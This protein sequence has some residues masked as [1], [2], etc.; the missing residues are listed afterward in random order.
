MYRT[1]GADDTIELSVHV[2]DISGNNV[3]S[4][5]LEVENVRYSMTG[6]IISITDSSSS[7]TTDSNGDATVSISASD[8]L[9]SGSY[10]VR[11]K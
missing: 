7:V 5:S 4:A 1:F 2:Q 11:L 9:K 6:E 3:S 8:S 10:G